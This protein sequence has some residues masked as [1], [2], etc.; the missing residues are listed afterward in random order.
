MNLL[1]HFILIIL[2]IAAAIDI[3]LGIGVLFVMA[4]ATWSI[5]KY[6]V[7]KKWITK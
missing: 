4:T 3:A 5:F 7:S 2:L 1:L 6:F